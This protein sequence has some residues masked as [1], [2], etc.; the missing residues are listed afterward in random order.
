M[1]NKAFTD[2]TGYKMDEVYGKNPSILSSQLQDEEFYKNMWN[3]I[4]LNGKWIGLIKN[5][6][7]ADKEYP[8]KV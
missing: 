6:R 5:R 2:I 8:L 4:K 7:K 1:V 3:D